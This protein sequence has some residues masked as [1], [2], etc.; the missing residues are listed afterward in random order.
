VRF[1]FLRSACRERAAT[2]LFDQVRKALSRHAVQ[3][4]RKILN[5]TRKRWAQASVVT[6]LAEA[7]G[8]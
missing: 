3:G 5:R 7:E 2:A 1:T 8:G 4:W 6:D